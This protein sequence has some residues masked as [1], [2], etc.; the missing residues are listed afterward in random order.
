MRKTFV[1]YFSTCICLFIF[2][3][4]FESGNAFI[5]AQEKEFRNSIGLEFVLIPA[6]VFLMGSPG[7][8]LHRN[9]D[10]RQYKAEVSSSFYMQTTE[11]TRRQWTSLMGRKWL[12]FFRRKGND[13]RPV[14]KV[15]WHDCMKFIDKLN[16]LGEGVYRLPTEAEWEYAC[17]AGSQT[18][19]SWGNTIECD[20]AMFCNNTLKSTRCIPYIEEKGLAVDQPAPVKSYAPNAYGLYD[21][22]GNVWEWCSDWYGKYPSGPT[23]DPRGPNSGKFRVRRGGSWFKQGWLCRSANRNYGHPA[24]REPTLGFRVI[25][26]LQ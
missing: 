19:Y 22:H 9:S 20:Q 13:D 8:E 12:A 7:D 17:R 25:K 4:L 2:W 15:S 23:K 14:V 10:E 18:A 5:F 6:G 11:V 16:E 24:T 21:M 26:E 1:R 3:C